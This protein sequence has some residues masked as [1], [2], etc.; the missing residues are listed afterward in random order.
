MTQRHTLRLALVSILCS[1][2]LS[3]GAARAADA[4][5]L[6]KAAE[7]MKADDMKEARRLID[8]CGETDKKTLAFF[9]VNAYFYARSDSYANAATASRTASR[10][11]E[12]VPEPHVYL[13]TSL[14][15]AGYAKDALA[16]AQAAAKLFPGDERFVY[17]A[18]LAQAAMGNWKE[19]REGFQRVRQGGSPL[20]EQAKG[21]LEEIDKYEAAVK[22]GEAEKT[23]LDAKLAEIKAKADRVRYSGKAAEDKLSALKRKYDNERDQVARDF[24]QV[25]NRLHRPTD[26]SQQAAYRR[27][28]QGA[29][30]EAEYRQRRIDQ[31]YRPQ[32]SE[33]QTEISRHVKELKDVIGEQ[34]P[35]LDQKTKLDAQAKREQAQL[36]EKMKV[37][38]AKALP[39]TP[40]RVG[41]LLTMKPEPA[42][43]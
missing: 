7:A 42:K 31:R 13:A 27:A 8:T 38:V 30:A 19:A 3:G 22:A 20:G 29:S 5:P 1:L 37:E 12:K 9:V 15:E 23:K 4:H 26:P 28:Y 41:E 21:H 24:N 10:L 2:L 34:R 32:V 17:A 40:Q 6:V 18:A 25:V 39:L 35:F 16:A 14:A 43:K 11:D 36:R 33:I